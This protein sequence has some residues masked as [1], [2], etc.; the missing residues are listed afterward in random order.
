M[1]VTAPSAARFG[2]A[3][4]LAKEAVGV[5]EDDS[6]LLMLGDHLFRSTARSLPPDPPP[7][8]PALASSIALPDN[9]WEL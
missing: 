8:R 6:F 2:H 3:V 7:R 1:E 5:H 4:L 9:L